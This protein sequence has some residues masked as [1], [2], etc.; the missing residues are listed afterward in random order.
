MYKNIQGME[1]RLI[2]IIMHNGEEKGKGK[3]EL[4]VTLRG[5][6]LPRSPL[7]L[8]QKDEL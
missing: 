2:L 7:L 8:S 1:F 4:N 6:S 5:R 3:N